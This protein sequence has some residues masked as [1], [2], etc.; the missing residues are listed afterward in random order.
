MVGKCPIRDQ[1]KVDPDSDQGTLIYSRTPSGGKVRNNVTVSDQFR[2]DMT[3]S[4]RTLS[5]PGLGLTT[6]MTTVDSWLSVVVVRAAT[7]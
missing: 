6:A 3:V 2:K 4:D 7:D 1:L 5:A